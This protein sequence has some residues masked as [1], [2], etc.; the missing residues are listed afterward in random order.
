MLA[1][2]IQ[3]LFFQYGAGE[4]AFSLQIETFNINP[5]SRAVL[6]GPSGCGKSTLLNLIAGELVPDRGNL[7]VLG[8]DLSQFSEQQRR[9]FRIQNIGFVFQDFPLVNYLSAEENVLL[10][11]RINPSLQLKE[12][13]FV[14]AKKLLVD[15]GL[16]GKN[17]S[18]PS[19][20]S[21]GESQRVAIARALITNPKILLA[22]EP[23]AGLDPERTS[24]VI[25]LLEDLVE[26]RE[27][28]MV[29]VT[30]DPQVRSRFDF[31][32]DFTA[33]KS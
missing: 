32:Y 1:I 23:T 20:L 18:L 15:L 5:G 6:F 33:G 10:P 4:G 7:S 9:V 12:E 11:Y 14:Q 31:F 2:D 30:H 24:S 8:Q 22:D 28:T 29:V 17:N 26:K 21:Q 27:M 3:N 13:S 16:E 19:Q 25:A